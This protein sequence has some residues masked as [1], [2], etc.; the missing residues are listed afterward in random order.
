MSQ[1][2]ISVTL[3]PRDVLGKKVRSLR[4]QGV[5]PAVIHDHGKPSLHVQGD[6]GALLKV[7]HQAGMHHPVRLSANGKQFTALI[8]DVDFEPRKHQLSHLVFNAVKANEKVE[9]VV[10]IHARYDE[11][12][13]LSPAERSN[14]LVITNVDSVSVKALP[15][16]LPDVLY[17]N[18]EKLKEV[19]DHALMS[20]LIV[21]AN[22]ELEVADETQAIASVYEPSA[23]AAANDAAGGDAAEEDAASVEAEHESSAEEGT[24]EDEPRP[25]GK[26]E[27]E[28]KQQGHNPEKA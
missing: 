24:S 2:V 27:F 10:P 23:I 3:T 28:D 9:A 25:G 19:G 12:N 11:G 8:K 17:Y 6:A 5:V 13:E 1:D 14:L 15:N 20:D 21:P 26:R 4:K 16:D 22:V 7:Y 18:G